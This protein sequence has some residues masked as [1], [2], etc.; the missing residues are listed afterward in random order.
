MMS[1]EKEWKGMPFWCQFCPAKNRMRILLWSGRNLLQLQGRGRSHLGGFSAVRCKGAR[2]AFLLFAY[3]AGIS[4]SVASG[5]VR[6][7]PG[8]MAAGVMPVMR[9]QMKIVFA[10]FCE[11]ALQGERTKRQIQTGIGAA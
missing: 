10:M 8:H 4:C 5:C 2:A 6:L 11:K 9:Q 3:P 1:S 7:H